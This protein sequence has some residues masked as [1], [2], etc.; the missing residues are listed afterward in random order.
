MR[1]STVAVMLSALVFP[2]AGQFYLRQ[3]RLGIL[4]M[5]VAVSATY[6]IVSVSVTIALELSA[7]VQSGIIPT[8]VDAITNL[9]S[10]QLSA[11]TQGT[12]LATT[13][14][15]MCWFIGVVSAYW[16]GRALEKRD[17]VAQHP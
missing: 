4:L 10:Q 14:L 5:A 6:F 8:D 15:L 3:W 9:V 11:T 17:T 7:K 12:N 13:L 16:Q 2:G 1:K